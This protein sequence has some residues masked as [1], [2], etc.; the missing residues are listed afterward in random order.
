M[1]SSLPHVIDVTEATFK[2][3]V[4]DKSMELPVLLDFWAEW[5][6]P[7]KTLG[8]ILETV[9]ESFGG[10]FRLAKVDVD[11]NANLAAQFGAQSIPAVYAIFQ[12]ALVDRFQ[13]A[14]PRPQI[15]AFVQSILER[16]G[17]QA[18]PATATPTDPLHAEAHW[19]SRLDQRPDDGEALLAL[20]RILLESGRTE[21][22][23]D[24]LGRVAVSMTEYNAAQSI[25]ALASLIEPLEAAGGES[26]LRDR[27][28]SDPTDAEAAY[29]VA[30]ADAYR[31]RFKR[32]LT[33]LIDQ[34]AKGDSEVRDRARTAA[35]TVFEAAGRS[36]DEVEGLRRQLGRLLF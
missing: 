17:V 26:A 21:D 34:V 13:G 2:T 19:R 30:C 3:E 24:V 1:A 31:G 5:C 22:A 10:A 29:L 16:C 23:V 4:L 7:C 28:T 6:G 35:A 33:A 9:A 36:D 12:G 8:P 14:L 20:G 25:L 27:L 15:E 11:Q 32:S 18:E